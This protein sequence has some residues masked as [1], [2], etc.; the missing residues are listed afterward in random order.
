MSNEQCPGRA[1]P[2]GP[3]FPGPSSSAL[4]TGTDRPSLPT[5]RR[6]RGNVTMDFP[7]TTSETMKGQALNQMTPE[8]RGGNAFRGQHSSRTEVA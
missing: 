6:D 1:R 3:V 7:F 8:V 2:C 5:V 4:L